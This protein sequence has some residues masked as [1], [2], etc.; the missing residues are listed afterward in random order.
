MIRKESLVEAIGAKKKEEVS[1]TWPFDKKII[2]QVISMIPSQ[3]GKVTNSC[4][5]E[6]NGVK[7]TGKLLQVM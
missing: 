3:N 1:S 2:F 7:T 6:A 4:Q 5:E